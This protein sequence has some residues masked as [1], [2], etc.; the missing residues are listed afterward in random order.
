[1][2]PDCPGTNI[3]APRS[4]TLYA[5]SAETGPPSALPEYDCDLIA[6][7]FAKPKAKLLAA[8]T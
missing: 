3:S 5:F 7:T 8:K 2:Y 4:P 1:M 6:E